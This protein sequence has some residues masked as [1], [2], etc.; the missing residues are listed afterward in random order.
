MPDRSERPLLSRS[1]NQ[2]RSV[3]YPGRAPTAPTHAAGWSFYGAPWL[4]PVAISG[5][6]TE[7]RSGGNTPKTLR[8]VATG[9]LRR[10]MVR[11]GSTVESVR[12][13]CKSPAKRGFFF[14]FHLHGPLLRLEGHGAGRRPCARRAGARPAREPDMDGTYASCRQRAPPASFAG[15]PRCAT[16]RSETG[17]MGR[18]APR[19][20]R[21]PRCWRSRRRWRSS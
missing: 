9:C 8:R 11:R 1:D 15:E 19:R 10:C 5:K 12:G 14:R 21:R 18:P 3:H 17:P 20:R 4:Q 6:S 16:A 7:P 13:L 2:E